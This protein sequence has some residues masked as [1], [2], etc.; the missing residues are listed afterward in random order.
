M[1]WEHGNGTW[2]EE[3]FTLDLDFLNLPYYLDDKIKLK[4]STAILRYL[5]QKYDLNGE[6]EEEKLRISLIEQQIKDLGIL[7]FQSAGLSDSDEAKKYS[8]KV[9]RD[10]LRLYSKFLR[11][12]NF[13]GGSNIS[14]VDFMI[15][16]KFDFHVLFSRTILDDFP[17]LKTYIK[18]FRSLPELQEYLNSTF[19]IR[20]PIVGIPGVCACGSSGYMP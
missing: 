6:T 5:A 19:Y 16:N 10:S 4:Q 12:R 13:F 20:R 7:F 3:K 18:I 9:A 14:H 15:Y 11:D 1:I 2:E 8:L 17:N